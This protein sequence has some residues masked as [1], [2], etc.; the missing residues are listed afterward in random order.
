VISYKMARRSFLRGAG[1][2]AALLYPLLRGIEARAAG[3]PAPLRF[4]VIHHPLGTQPAMWRP[5]A[6]ATTTTFMLP[7]ISAPFEPLR[8]YMV[9]ID[10]LNIVSATVAANGAAGAATHE[11][12]M[13]ALMTGQPTLGQ[14]GQQD[15]VAKGASIDQ[16]FLSKSPSLGALGTTSP[17]PFGSLQLAA[18]IRSDRDE[19]APRTM[20]YLDSIP[21]QTNLS[22]ARRPLAP[23]T[24]PITT[25]MR[26]FGGPLPMGTTTA[27]AARLLAQKKSILDFMRHDLTRMQTLVPSS[28]KVRIDTQADAIQKLESSI[29]ASLAGQ[30][31]TGPICSKPMTP[32]QFTQSGA[33]ASGTLAPKDANGNPLPSSLHG[34]DYYDPADAT[35]HPHQRL[36]RAQLALI[37][38]AFACDLVRVATFMWSA[39]TNWVVFP[40]A[41][42]GSRANINGVLGPAS[43]PHHPPSHTTDANTLA[44]LAQVDLFYAQQTAAALQQFVAA[45]DFDGNNLL[46]NTVVTYVSEVGRASDHNQ[47]NMPYAVFGG[48]NTRIVQGGKFLKVTDGHLPSLM[49]DGSDATNGLKGPAINR[50][51]NDVWLALAPI[52]GVN[53]PTL[54]DA[55]QYQGPLAG[56]TV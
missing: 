54:G 26:I 7:T 51:T 31:T 4:L 38:A 1:G 40:G 15:H 47:Y 52:F 28:E 36:G 16:L 33:G 12:G 35:N 2:S 25:F 19:I 24:S 8:P 53:L 44:W 11:G 45:T 56:I 20:S 27:D 32:E 6:T 34:V 43:T 46:D 48:K 49:G 30:T 9:M 3:M 21:N 10:G 13:V 39:G 37:Q 5:T 55:T 14:I 42:N 29:T 18:D 23:E 50:P 41:L 22:L 17:T